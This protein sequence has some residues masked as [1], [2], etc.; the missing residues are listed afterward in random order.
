MSY[1][2]RVIPF[3]M[4]VLFGLALL[5]LASPAVHADS[6]SI[7]ITAASL[8]S[9]FPTGFRIRVEATGDSELTSVA[10][11]LRIGQRTSGSYDY[12]CQTGSFA[13]LEDGVCNPLEIGKLVDGEL[14]WRTDTIGRYIPPGTIITYNFEVEDS[15]GARLETDRE[16]FLYRDVRALRGKPLEWSE[17]SQGPV[18]VAYYGPVK[19]RAQIVLDTILET[20]AKMGPLL[21]ADIETPIRVTMYNNNNDMLGALP[22]GSTTI[23]RELITEG[24]AFSADGMLL[25]L[26]GGRTVRGTASHEITHILVH[27][28]GD[29]VFRRV[30]LWLN[31]GLAEYAN[32]DPGYEYEIALDFAIATDRLIRPMFS[33]VYPGDP[34]DTIIFYG[35]YRNLIRLMI[36]KYGPEKMTRLMAGLKSGKN[37]EDAVK[38]AYGFG[39]REL[40]EEWRERIGAEVYVPPDTSESRPTPVPMRE[41]RLYSLT[42]QAGVE[43]VGAKSDAPTPTPTP[44]PEPTAAPTPIPP[45]TPT[46]PPPP[47]AA[48]A[49]PQPPPPSEPDDTIEPSGACFAPVNGPVPLDLAGPVLLLGLAGLGLRKRWKRPV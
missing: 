24:Q 11:R 35:M 5:P 41:V 48:A 42:P 29:S 2:V 26:G 46:Q 45:P 36:D 4:A 23:R 30:P 21:G 13:S 47:P 17:V 28:A 37:S 39:L 43:A 16:E 25:M 1:L 38:E 27:R 49:P 33:N 9:E 20:L 40:D 8:T 34:E 22:P 19:S 7:K 44:E 3:T 10:V 31:E 32:V 6:G 12:L 18:A 14:F 15:A